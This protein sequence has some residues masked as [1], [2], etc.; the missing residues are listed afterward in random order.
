MSTAVL[1]LLAA[2]VDDEDR[3]V[4][5]RRHYL[6]RIH[7][8][9]TPS[10]SWRITLNSPDD[11]GLLNVTGLTRA[12]FED[13]HAA[14]APHW[15]QQ[16]RRRQLHARQLRSIDVLGL[17]LHWVQSTMRAKTLCQVFATPPATVSRLLRSGMHSLRLVL[18]Q[19]PEAAIRWP[20]PA[21]MREFADA[22]TRY[23]PGLHDIFGFVDGVYFQCTSPDD[24]NT[25][26]AYFN[27]WRGMTSITNVLVFTPDGCI[28]WAS[29][30]CPGSWHDSRVSL[31]LYDLLLSDRTPGAF[32]LASDTAFNRGEEMRGKIVTPMK[33]DELFS[34]DPTIAA[35]QLEQHR[36]VVRVRQAAEW[37]M[38]TLQAA[39][40]RLKSMITW[41]PPSNR[42]LLGLI[43]HLFNYRTRRVGLNQTRSVY[44]Q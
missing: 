4:N 24:I 11:T 23:E 33:V 14:F 10:S 32:A 15:Q 39:F 19:L 8:G 26:N 21:Q 6:Q 1:L 41:H 28:A 25:Q 44:W 22:I 3:F 30:N 40:P 43:F 38:H 20:A 7:V 17:V 5:R 36:Q 31:R 27:D 12:A 34:D 9:P 35:Q 2:V 13:L 29:Y 37:G 18:S 42:D 16:R